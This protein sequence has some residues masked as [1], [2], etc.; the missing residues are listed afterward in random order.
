MFCQSPVAQSCGQEHKCYQNGKGKE[1][2]SSAGLV[3]FS[4]AQLK[5]IQNW[6][7]HKCIIYCMETFL[8]EIW[9]S[10]IKWSKPFG[11]QF[12]MMLKV[13]FTFCTMCT[14]G[15]PMW[16]WNFPGKCFAGGKIVP[17]GP[18]LYVILY[19]HESYVDNSIDDYIYKYVDCKDLRCKSIIIKICNNPHPADYSWLKTIPRPSQKY[20]MGV[21]SHMRVGAKVPNL[22]SQPAFGPEIA[23]SQDIQLFLLARNPSDFKTPHRWTCLVSQCLVSKCGRKWSRST[24]HWAVVNAVMEK[25]TLSAAHQP[26]KYPQDMR[27]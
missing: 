3:V 20:Y 10:A 15:F 27:I 26:S 5:P 11:F 2:A 1:H 17:S 6:I 18:A 25:Y 21:P 22:H 4:G 9:N 14:W 12:P 13:R 16:A 19:Y 8:L 23:M 24:Q 7:W